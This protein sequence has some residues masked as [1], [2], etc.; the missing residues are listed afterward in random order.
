[1]ID[2]IWLNSLDSY[3]CSISKTIKNMADQEINLITFN[4]NLK[5]KTLAIYQLQKYLFDS[6][7]EN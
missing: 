7:F 5:Q 4:V 2:N 1:M 3:N 6:K